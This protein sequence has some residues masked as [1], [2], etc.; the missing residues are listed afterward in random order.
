MCCQVI[1]VVLFGTYLFA[2][3]TNKEV[4]LKIMLY[5]K[6]NLELFI[7]VFGKVPGKNL[8]LALILVALLMF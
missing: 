8:V 5:R 7:F 6:S 3:N 1:L 2:C 4:K